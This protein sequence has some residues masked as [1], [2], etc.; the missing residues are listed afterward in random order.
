MKKKTREVTFAHDGTKWILAGSR[1]EGLKGWKVQDRKTRMPALVG[2]DGQKV[3]LL[4]NEMDFF[5]EEGFISDDEYDA[6]HSI[7]YK[8]FLES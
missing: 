4:L 6:I 7:V 8:K 1:L 2:P 5:I 3:K